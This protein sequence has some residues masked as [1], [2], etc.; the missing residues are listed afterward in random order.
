MQKLRNDIAQWKGVQNEIAQGIYQGK[1]E[2]IPQKPVEVTEY[3]LIQLTGTLWVAGGLVDQ[4]W[5]HLL[6]HQV[7]DE[8]MK[9]HNMLKEKANGAQ[10]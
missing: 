9:L 8:E 4:P 7:V 6:L 5:L 10:Q 1:P 3:E 2:D